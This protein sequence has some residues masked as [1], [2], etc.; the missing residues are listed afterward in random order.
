MPFGLTAEQVSTFDVEKLDKLMELHKHL[1]EE[2]AKKAFFSAMAE[3]Q[4]EMPQVERTR[5][6]MN[7]G[8][9]TER[10]RYA[11]LEDLMEKATPVLAK[12]GLSVRFV[13]KDDGGFLH[14]TC[15]V[16]H[17]EGHKEE[18]PFTLPKEGPPQSNQTQAQASTNS[19]ARRYALCN[20]L[21][22][23]VKDE[24]D[25]GAGADPPEMIS[26]KQVAALQELSA[27]VGEESQ[28]L[29]FMGVA[30]IE[31]IPAGEF[32]RAERALKKKIG[33]K[34]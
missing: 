7:K 8:G 32:A 28:F 5:V 15:I 18:S 31:D 33:G 12:S 26:E 6:V 17:A 29:K 23:V 13:Q 11:A 2:S 3:F 14:I 20:A 21:N 19:Y 9:V 27:K 22:I 4:G 25:D 16:A 34:K 30:S 10:Y 1:G 24:D